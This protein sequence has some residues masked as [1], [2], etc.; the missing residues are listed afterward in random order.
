MKSSGLQK[1]T[2]WGR[3]R[4][5]IE[6]CGESPGKSNNEVLRSTKISTLGEKNALRRGTWVIAWQ[7]QHEGR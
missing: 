2:C 3:R 5:S 4:R 1:Y 6:E 7:I